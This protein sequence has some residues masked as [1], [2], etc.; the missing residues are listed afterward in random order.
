MK[1]LQEYL[2]LHFVVFL[3]VGII[4]Q[5][6]TNIW[7][8]GFQNLFIL[9]LFLVAFL[10]ILHRFKKQIYFTICTGLL[11]VCI[12]GSVVYFQN[13]K[14]YKTYY[15]YFL[16]ENI[17]AVF[18]IEKVLKSGNYYDKYQ[19]KVT[20][21][22]QQKTIGKLLLNIKKDS[23]QKPL[24]VDD[25]LFLKPIFKELIPP[26]NPYQFSY[27]KYLA[28]KGIYKQVFTGNQKIK[29][30]KIKKNSLQGLAYLF[31]E[32]IKKRLQKYYFAKNELAVINALLL[33]ER[34]DI[35]KNLLQDYTRAGAIHI[36]AVSGLHVGIILLILS[37]FFKPLE[38]LKNG[39]VLK[40]IIIVL[41]LWVFA[42]V[43]GLS[44]SVVRAVTMFTAV[45]IGQSFKRKNVIGHS[46]IISMFLLLLVNPLFLFDVGFQLSYLAVFGIVWL[47]PKIC[48][49]WKPRY[50][51]V[52]K[53]WQ[54][55]GVSIAAQAGILPLSLYYFHQFPGLF[56][57]SN[58]VIIPFLGTILIGGIVVILFAFLGILPQFMADFYG[59]IIS[60]MN[61]FV[62]F[63]SHQ[64]QFLITNISFS[65]LLMMVFYAVIIFMARFFIDRNSKKLLYALIAIVLLQS[66]FLFEKYQKEKKQEFI[67]FHKSRNSILGN[68]IGEKLQVYH[69]LD[70]VKIRQQKLLIAYKVNEKV[71]LDFY[72]KTP[73]VF[74]RSNQHILRIDSLGIYQLNKL[75]NPIVLLQESP[76]IN[77]IRLIE[78]LQPVQIIADGSNY[79]SYVNRW[80]KTCLEK[81]ILFYY[82]GQKGAVII[83]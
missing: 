13:D 57:A 7:Q 64:E 26:L 83:D 75:K 66:V 33:G 59:L 17:T 16:S 51:I 39:I 12:G 72:Q 14:N 2:P 23:L 27:K 74:T 70:S 34:K 77:L 29:I 9:L 25:L 46:L 10:W 44:A 43:A 42:F 28:G 37:A 56:I 61:K 35:S 31:R 60:L 19:V 22:H 52:D 32:K 11:F 49:I 20:A 79:K 73:F 80:R 82:T 36:L 45:A 18:K 38:R 76:K 47:Q 5:F 81:G 71:V 53:G 78:G 48:A 3:I 63:I 41:L 8:F 21:I 1:K 15:E 50:K 69:H 4:L 24:H 55:F 54:L 68:R 62:S 30:F 65:F 67:V 58:L 6:Y 40:T